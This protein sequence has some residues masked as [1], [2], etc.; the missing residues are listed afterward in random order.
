MSITSKTT[1]ECEGGK[2]FL[3]VC[4]SKYKNRSEYWFTYHKQVRKEA[5]AVVQ[6]LPTML[7]VEYNI[8]PDHFFFEGGIDPTENWTVE[9]EET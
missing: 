3:S 1:P 4:Y 8:T 6:A 5:E 7:R 9:T 2:L